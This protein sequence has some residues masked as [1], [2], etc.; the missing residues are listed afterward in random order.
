[1]AREA[2]CGGPL[3]ELVAARPEAP[4]G[5]GTADPAVVELL[6]GVAVEDLLQPLRDRDA[7]TACLAG[8]WLAFGHL[9]TAHTLCQPLENPDGSYW[10][11][12]MHRRE[13][14]FDNSHYWFRRVGRHPLYPALGPAVAPLAGAVTGAPEWLRRGVWDPFAF[15]DLCSREI[16]RDSALER[17]CVAVQAV[18]WEL[19][20]EHCWQQAGG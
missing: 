8:V 4:L 9:D 19:L 13:P 10:H 12:L 20:F 16:G 2:A 15:I 3:S 18:E 17:L 11:G 7:A 1:M 14:D 6:R 5:P